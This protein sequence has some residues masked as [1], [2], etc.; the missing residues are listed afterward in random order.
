VHKI[1]WILAILCA[2]SWLA[3][4]IN[5]PGNTQ[6]SA[7][8]EETAWRR[9]A[10]GWENVNDWAFP[11]EISPPALHPCVMSLLMVA[12]SL[13]VAIAKKEPAT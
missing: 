9:T 10:D 4:E 7:A 6:N 11:I 8:Q 2:V 5:L 12:I 3:S 1:G 13:S